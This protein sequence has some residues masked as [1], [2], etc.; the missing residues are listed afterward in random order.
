MFSEG[1]YVLTQLVHRNGYRIQGMQYNMN[2]LD[3]KNR[4][5]PSTGC[6][7]TLGQDRAAHQGHH[8]PSAVAVKLG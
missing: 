8:D 7:H 4:V 2:A 5:H 3:G 1:T 6:R